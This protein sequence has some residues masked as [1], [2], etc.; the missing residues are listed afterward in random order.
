[1]RTKKLKSKEKKKGKRNGSRVKAKDNVK[2]QPPP[3][4]QAES[5]QTVATDADS[6]KRVQE[7][8]LTCNLTLS[9]VL[10]VSNTACLLKTSL[11]LSGTHCHKINL[12][13]RN[14]STSN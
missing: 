1:V 2:K 9:S 11:R 8:V 6:G 13:A 12:P 14:A 3:T 5:E 10:P 7:F 4:I